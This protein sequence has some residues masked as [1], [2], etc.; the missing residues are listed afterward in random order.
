MNPAIDPLTFRL[1]VTLMLSLCSFSSSVRYCA[2]PLIAKCILNQSRVRDCWPNIAQV[3]ITSHSRDI[4]HAL[5]DVAWLL[6]STDLRISFYDAH[7]VF[8]A[9]AIYGVIS[10]VLTYQLLNHCFPRVIY[11]LGHCLTHVRP[12]ATKA[13]SLSF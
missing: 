13:C 8:S 2:N 11:S 4:E 9:V 7:P 12:M 6:P 5:V 3:S 1:D 10:E